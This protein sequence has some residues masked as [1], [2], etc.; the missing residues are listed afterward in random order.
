MARLILLLTLCCLPFATLAATL[1]PKPA[2]LQRDIDFWVQIYAKVDTHSGLLHDPWNL[3]VVYE[4]IALP[5]AVS[6]AARQAFIDQAKSRYEAALYQLAAGK[7]SNLSHEE[8]VA[9]AAWPK[10]TSAAR[11]RQAAA[12]IRFQLGQA[13]RFHAGL[14]RS[15]QWRGHIRSVLAEFGLPQEL[16]VLP[17]VESSFN[18]SVYSKAAAAGMWQFMPQ[19]AR[20]F[21]TVN[22]LLDERLDPYIASHAAARLLHSNL[23]ATGNWP[24]AIT[25]YNYGPGGVSRAV[26][27]MNSDDIATVV[28]HYRG[29]AFGFASRNFYVSFL[30][31]LEV[32]RNHKKYFGDVAMAAPLDY[33]RVTLAEYVQA[34]TLVR[35]TGTSLENLRAHNPALL[36][37]I[38]AGEKWIPQGYTVKLPRAGLKQPL[39]SA[40]AAIPESQRFAYQ[41]PDVLHRIAKGETLSHIASRYK[42]SVRE[43]MAVNG[44]TGHNIRAGQSLRLPGRIDSALAA[45]AGQK[46]AGAEGSNVYVIQPG[47][48]LWRIARRFNRTEQELVAWNSLADKH[49]ITPGKTL[50]VG[51]STDY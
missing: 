46:T 4:Q 43:L 32:D 40:L 5:P 31:A 44:L 13:D 9:L 18:P 14:V 37:P 1:F 48:S 2:E 6:G 42:I 3:G 29:P 8:Q 25:A 28:R 33:D 34:D 41:K 20:Q 23:R 24:L 21:M 49:R 10:G 22:E 16:D 35:A 7:R 19:T 30:A 45:S 38:W 47:D 11:F 12:E 51:M 26:K 27:A 39:A 36:E 15:G 17:H 50:R